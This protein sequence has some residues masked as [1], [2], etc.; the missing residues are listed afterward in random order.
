VIVHAG[1]VAL[2][3]PGGWRGAL[4]EGPSGVGKSDLALRILE[5]GFSLVS[6]DRTRLWACQE[7]LYGACPEPISGLIEV[8][9][10]GVVPHPVRAFAEIRLIVLCEA[11][12]E[13]LERLPEPERR[14]LE[15]VS[16][17]VLRLHALQAS[18]PAKIR[19]A[20]THL[21]ARP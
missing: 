6:D 13:A 8:R 17:P 12:S 9:G 1:L 21:G 15:G 4:I 10:L 7:R 20:L 19:L 5:Q 18:A 2:Y 3:G 11:P 16:L 14:E